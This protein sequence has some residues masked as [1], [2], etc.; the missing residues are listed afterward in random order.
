MYANVLSLQDLVAWVTLST[1]S[2]PSMESLPIMQTVGNLQS[3]LLSPFNY[4]KDDPSLNS[5]DT[6]DVRTKV[7]MREKRVNNYGITKTFMCSIE[8]QVTDEESLYQNDT[9]KN[10]LVNGIK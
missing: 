6:L 10:N 9:Y 1:Y 8:Y 4:Y 7:S 3:F 2:V 5:R